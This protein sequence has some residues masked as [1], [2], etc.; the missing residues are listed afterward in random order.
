M[1]V[2]FY[3]FGGRKKL[4]NFLLVISD[5]R[6]QDRCFLVDYGTAAGW[7]HVLFYI[8][9]TPYEEKQGK[10]R[11]SPSSNEAYVNN[12]V[13]CGFATNLASLV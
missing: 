4:M 11:R 1:C 13:Y 7:C 3:F 5:C 2:I 10:V 6:Q 8:L 9:L 12:M